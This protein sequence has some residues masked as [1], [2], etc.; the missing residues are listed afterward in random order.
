[1]Q[2][3]SEERIGPALL[4]LA[5]A[6]YLIAVAPGFR[7]RRAARAIAITLYAGVF[8]GAVAWVLLWSAGIDIGR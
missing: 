4:L 8:L 7:Y 5:T 3:F 1:M 2:G 6:M